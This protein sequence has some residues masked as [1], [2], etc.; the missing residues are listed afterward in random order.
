MAS[1]TE[2]NWKFAQCFGDKGEVE[3]ITE[4]DIISTVEFDHTGDYLATGDKGGRVV[5]FERNE[6]KKGCEYRFHTEFQSHEPEFDYLKSLEIEEKINKIKWCKRQNSA[7]FL[8]STNDKTVKLWKVFEKSIKVVAENNHGDGQHVPVAGAP[9]RLPKL[10]HHDTIVAAVPRKVYANAHAY[11]INSISINSDGETYISAD[12]LRIN[13]WNL[14]ISDQSFN[15]V[16]IKPVNM[17]ELTEVITA[18]EFH[19]VHCNLFMYSSSKGT[20]K[21]SD[22][23]ESALCDQHAKLFEEEEDPSNKSFFSE[24]ISSISDVKFSKDGRYILSRD[25]LTLKVWDI[26]MES[27]PVQTINI[28]DHLRN[29][30]CDLYE[31]DCIFDKFECTFSGDGNNVL[32]GSYNNNFYIYDRNGKNDVTLQADKSAFKAKRVGSAKNKMMART[33]NGK[34]DDINVESIDFTK[35][36]LHASWHPNENSIAIAATNNLFIFTIMALVDSGTDPR[37]WS[38]LAVSPHKVLPIL[39]RILQDVQMEI[40][41]LNDD[42]GL[43]SQDRQRTNSYSY[44]SS[45]AGGFGRPTQSMGA[46]RTNGGGK[47]RPMYLKP[48]CSARVMGLPAAES[49]RRTVPTCADVGTFLS[50]TA[51]VIRTGIVKMLENKKP[52]L[53]LLCKK[54][55]DVL[56]DVEQYNK[57]VMPSRCQAQG[58]ARPCNSYKFQ[59]VEPPPGQL[60]EGC[61]DYQEIKIQEQTNKLTMGTIPGSMVVILHDDLV[62]HAKSGDDVTIT[63]TVIRRWKNPVIGERCDIELALLA[64]HVFIHNEQRVGVGITEEQR[65]DFEHFWEHARSKDVNKPFTARNQILSQICPKVYGLYIVKLA[66]MLVLTGGVAKNDDKSGLKVRG[67]PHLL[68]V[69][70]PGTGKSQ[71][72]K[73]AAELNPRSVLTTGIGS[74]S[75]G[76]TVT[77]VR[78]GNEWQLEAG[79]LVLADRGLCCIDEFGGMREHDKVAIHEAME[80]Q[81]ISIAKAGIVCKLN[82]RCS[83]IAATNPKG[84]YDPNESVSINIALASPLLS[85]FDIVLVLMDTG[86]ANWDHKISSYILDTRMRM[87]GQFVPKRKRLTGKEIRRRRKKLRKIAKRKRMEAMGL[88]PGDD[89]YDS[90]ISDDGSS[91]GRGSTAGQDEGDDED[92]E[93]LEQEAR[94]DPWSLEKVKAYLIWIKSTFQPKLTPPAEQVLV[95]YYQLQRKADLRNAAR[96]TIRLLE[97]LIRLSQAHARLMARDLV[98]VEDAVV[99]VSVMEA[100]AQGGAAVMENINPLHASFPKVAEEE[101]GRQ[102]TAILNRLG[103]AHL[104][105]H[106]QESGDIDDEGRGA[107]HDGE[108]D[109]VPGTDTEEIPGTGIKRRRQDGRDDDYDHRRDHYR[110][111][112]SPSKRGP[113]GAVGGSNQDSSLVSARSTSSSASTASTNVLSTGSM[114]L[115]D[116][117]EAEFLE[118]L[119]QS[120]PILDNNP[121][122]IT[123]S[124]YGSVDN[125]FLEEGF[126][127]VKTEEEEAPLIDRRFALRQTQTQHSVGALSP[128][129]SRREKGKSVIRDRDTNGDFDHDER[130]YS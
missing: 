112:L 37:L 115:D 107:G 92:D 1:E 130:P 12:D 50:I 76:L 34:K 27:R 125:G 60:P 39:D 6:G 61:R 53:C 19:P 48:K 5:L 14:N 82:T 113:V 30:L 121:N 2:H 59:I 3:D 28:H 122:N 74:S 20:I 126:V 98:T 8:L 104:A 10:T 99:V 26:N 36:I 106:L 80:Q 95:S 57:V 38:D 64:N 41:R 13:L 72:L 51:T 93:E 111:A 40:I 49:R 127:D 11:H 86:N 15:I 89:G 68:L 87:D 45:A 73:Y 69:G 101:Y 119:K 66:V 23:R 55:F 117:A 67:E 97:S 102:E 108:D 96:T 110:A 52:V 24:I 63:G 35:K 54:T 116:Q 32:T 85:R 71:F 46:R 47:K 75:A 62:D 91:V 79:A 9:L 17:E 88:R 120:D 7:H 29:K 70:D 90:S 128:S 33:K 124:Q 81:S 56:A 114:V 100:T 43:E 44:S 109:V 78:D 118:R 4:A 31:N 22:M 94:P 103:L 77:A 129:V 58:N 84:K 16:D 65:L 42:D 83:V 21:L 105:S 18:A 123:I 25:Y